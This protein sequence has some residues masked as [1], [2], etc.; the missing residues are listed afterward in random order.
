MKF[1]TKLLGADRKTVIR[2]IDNIELDLGPDL[3]GF[4]KKYGADVA[5]AL[6][7]DAATVRAQAW[8]RAR[9]RLEGDKKKSEATIRAEFAKEFELTANGRQADPEKQLENAQKLAGKLSD[10]AKRKLLAE[11]QAS[12]A[13]Q[14]PTKKAA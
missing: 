14:K 12:L 4:V 3:D 11:L 9:M 5:H 8:T 6:I 7:V 2:Q 1:T 13:P 10:D